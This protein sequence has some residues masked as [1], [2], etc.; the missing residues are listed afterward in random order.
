MDTAR[1]YLLVIKTGNNSYLPIEWQT[2]KDYNKENLYT[3]DGIDS[4]T[5]R[6]TEGELL[7][8][9]VEQN[10]L[11]MD[12]PFRQVAIIYK[13]NGKN[14][15]VK[16]GIIYKNTVNVLSEEE[17]LD[18]LLDIV[19]N[20]DKETLNNVIQQCNIKEQSQEVEKFIYVLKNINIFKEK[21]KNGIIAALNTFNEIPYDLRRKIRLKVAKKIIF[22]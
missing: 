14:R 12:D 3:L 15:E 13:E 10:I 20:D 7:Y 19:T 21:G 16:E 5:S 22:K 17:F 1:N 2:I 6:F 18:V 4:F 8:E 9:A 11:S